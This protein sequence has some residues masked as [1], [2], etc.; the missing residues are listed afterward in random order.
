MA[1]VLA[2]MFCFLLKNE[3]K[4]KRSYFVVLSAIAPILLFLFVNSYMPFA[5]LLPVYGYVWF[6]YLNPRRCRYWVLLVLCVILP[7]SFAFSCLFIQLK[8]TATYPISTLQHYFNQPSVSDFLKAFKNVVAA[9]YKNAD[10]AFIFKNSK[11]DIGCISSYLLFYYLLWTGSVIQLIVAFK[12]G[13]KLHLLGMLVVYALSFFVCV[14]HAFYGTGSWTYMRGLNVVLVFSL[15][16]VCILEWPKFQLAFVGLIFM[17]YFPFV[18]AIRDD[19]TK[20]FAVWNE[21][22]G[23]YEVFE[24]Y[25]P[26]FNSKLATCN[27][28]D[29]WDNTVAFYGVSFNFT[30][31]IPVG[32]SWNYIMDG[33]LVSK[34][35]YIITDRNRDWAFPGYEKTY[36]DGLINIFKKEP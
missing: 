13:K 21:Y 6:S 26:I 4:G 18:S 12:T 25:R 3:N 24:K 20:R 14:F 17:Q 2:G 7:A 5:F 30:C 28:K 27:S 35:R 10:V 22:G 23:G 9:N 8:T 11:V 33:H 34:P 32:L 31:A 16:I 36:Q 29:P 15:Y 1:I 19:M